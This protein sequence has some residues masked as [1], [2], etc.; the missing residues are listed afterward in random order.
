AASLTPKKLA[1]AFG[2][3]AQSHTKPAGFQRLPNGLILQWGVSSVVAPGGFITF[4]MAFP[5]IAL[6]GSVSVANGNVQGQVSSDLAALTGINAYVD[7]NLNLA[8]MAIGL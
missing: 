1:D 6:W 3:S 5:T 4:R 7:R 2:G 8:W